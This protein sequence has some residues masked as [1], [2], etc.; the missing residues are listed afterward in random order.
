MNSI[1]NIFEFIFDNYISK[2]KVLKSLL[3]IYCISKS[4]AIFK[5]FLKI[6]QQIIASDFKCKNCLN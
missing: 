5:V 2:S 6:I 4:Y 1:T 3:T